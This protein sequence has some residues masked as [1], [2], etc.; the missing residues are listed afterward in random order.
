MYSKTHKTL[1][2]I[3]PRVKLNIF[4]GIKNVGGQTVLQRPLSWDKGVKQAVN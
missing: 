1:P 4:N 3:V 2:K